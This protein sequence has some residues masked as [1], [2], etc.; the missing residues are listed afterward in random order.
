METK[1][2]AALTAASTDLANV[3]IAKLDDLHFVIAD[4]LNTVYNLTMINNSLVIP[5]TGTSDGTE[6]SV[7]EGA[8]FYV[9][10][11]VSDGDDFS[12][13]IITRDR[14]LPGLTL[15]S[16]YRIFR[17]GIASVGYD[18][19]GAYVIEFGPD[20]AAVAVAGTVQTTNTVTRNGVANAPTVEYASADT[21]IATISVSGLITGVAPGVVVITATVQGNLA[22]DTL[23]LTVT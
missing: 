1:F 14:G 22:S 12:G 21:G 20:P 4:E 18:G 13:A 15:G 6:V 11:L 2:A 23:T 8:S 3:V 7:G 10:N 5:G 9:A 19:T 16:A 17:A